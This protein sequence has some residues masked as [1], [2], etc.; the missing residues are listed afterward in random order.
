M[1]VVAAV[2]ATVEPFSLWDASTERKV[3]MFAYVGSNLALVLESRTTK[4]NY[5][6]GGS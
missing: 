4:V 3:L 6:L 2:F 1:A 5:W